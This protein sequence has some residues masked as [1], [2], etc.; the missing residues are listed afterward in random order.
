MRHHDSEPDWEAAYADEAPV[1]SGRPNEQLLAEV[2]GLTPGRALDVGCGEGADAVWLAQQGW[3]VTAIDVSANALA[4]ARAAAEAAG[5]R[6]DFRQTELLA[7]EPGT[8]DLVSVFYPAL[9]SVGA[10]PLGALLAQVAPGGTLLVV[11][12]ADVDR[13]RALA[14]G[15]D[16]DHY[17]GHEHV[18]AAFDGDR[19]EG[20]TVR[21]DRRE[22]S[23]REGAG[24]HHHHD[25]VVVA[26]RAE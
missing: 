17:V 19:G 3:H 18:V 13:E 16:P 20:W 21:V 7:L 15:F 6:I 12:H 2:S 11:H 1:W 22:R 9:R 10:D 23:L 4:R 26:R 5:V 24:A 25:L 14:H 8:F